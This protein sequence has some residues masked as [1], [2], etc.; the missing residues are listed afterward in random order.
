MRALG[1][2]LA[3]I[4]LFVAAGVFYLTVLDTSGHATTLQTTT[5]ECAVPI[6]PGQPGA[7]GCPADPMR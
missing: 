4:V 1:I 7:G 5:S 6:P 2:F 3:G